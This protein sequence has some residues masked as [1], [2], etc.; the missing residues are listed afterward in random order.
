[1]LRRDDERSRKKMFSFLLRHLIIGVVTGWIVLGV[2]I[3]VDVGGLRSLTIQ[4]GLAPIVFPLLFIFFAITFGSAAMGI[5]IMGI[6]DDD[7]DD[8]D[9]FKIKIPPV[10]GTLTPIKVHSKSR[11]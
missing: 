1:M 8:D 10:F 2:F 6:K 4:N 3:A 9:G 11:N 5:G 7:D